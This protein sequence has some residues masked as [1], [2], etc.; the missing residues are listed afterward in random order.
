MNIQKRRKIFFAT[1]DSKVD[2][3][4]PANRKIAGG[5]YRDNVWTQKHYK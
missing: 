3:P 1:T 4:R 2:V 5:Y